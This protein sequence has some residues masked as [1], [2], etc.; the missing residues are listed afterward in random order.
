MKYIIILL[1]LTGCHSEH[2]IDCHELM[3]YHEFK[4]GERVKIKGTKW[5]GMVIEVLPSA[6]FLVVDGKLLCNPKR[7]RVEKNE[8]IQTVF[9]YELQELAK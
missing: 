3:D 5:S 1:L 8:K 6:R 9:D 7:V 4:V 2:T